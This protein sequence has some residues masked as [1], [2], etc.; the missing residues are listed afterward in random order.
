MHLSF[1]T[2]SDLFRDPYLSAQNLALNLI[3]MWA[4]FLWMDLNMSSFYCSLWK[5]FLG[6]RVWGGPILFHYFKDIILNSDLHS[7]RCLMICLGNLLTPLAQ[8]SY[9]VNQIYWQMTIPFS[10]HDFSPP[11]FQ[12]DFWYSGCICIKD[13]Y[14]WTLGH[15]EYS[16]CVFHFQIILSTSS[17][18][19]S[20]FLFPHHIQHGQLSPWTFKFLPLNT[21][22]L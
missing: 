12:L 19:L 1:T 6:C 4:C 7:C 18:N 2:I 8:L 13:I 10:K 5:L 21:D 14:S 11:F 9:N 17:L 22:Y 3:M 15:F 16:F 20:S